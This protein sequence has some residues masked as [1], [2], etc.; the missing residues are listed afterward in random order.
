M[1]GR[2]KNINYAGSTWNKWDLHVHSNASDGKG[3]PQ[4]IID[5]ALEM[6]LSVIALTDHHTVKNI[7]E[8]KQLG[9][10]VGI[11]V[12][13]GIEF[14]TEYGAKSVHMIG[15]FPDKY[16][17]M[18]LDQKA[19]EQLILNKLNLSEV[20][21]KAK[22]KEKKP[23]A[24]DEEA[25]KIGMFKVQVDFKEASDL[26]H[27]YGGLVSVHAG[28]KANSIEEMK[29][30]GQAKKNVKDVVDSLGPLKEELLKEYI[31]ICE[32]GSLNDKNA[33]FYINNYNTP[34]IV[35]SDAHELSKIGSLYTWI[36]GDKDFEGLRQIVYE[37]EQRVKIQ[38]N[39]PEI[40]GDYQVIESLEVEHIDFGKQVIP[41]NPNLNSII[42]GRS[43]GKSILLGCIAKLAN[44]SGAIKQ[45]NE[46]YEKYVSDV[47]K[48]MKL[49][50]KD[51]NESV[52]RKVE[53]FPQSYINKLASDSKET[54]SLIESI[55]KGDEK[56]KNA[57]EAYD[58]STSKNLV[59]ISNEIENLFKLQYRED[60]LVKEIEKIGDFK[61]IKLEIDKL[62]KEL[63]IAKNASNTRISGDEEQQYEK[64]K[65]EREKLNSLILKNENIGRQLDSLTF[66]EVT[67]EIS[68]DLIGLPE[69]IKAQII[70]EYDLLK[71]DM[72]DKWLALVE[73]HKNFVYM[74]KS[75]AEARINEIKNCKEY[76]LGEAFYKE[77]A[78]IE[79]L[80]KRLVVE[81]LKAEKIGDLNNK[82]T[83]V[84]EEIKKSYCKI[85]LKQ[86]NYY[87]I[88]ERI[89]SS[90]SL[91]KDEVKI[92]PFQKF[93]TEKFIQFIDVNLNKRNSQIAGLMEY[94]YST[95]EDFFKLL[96]SLFSGIMEEKISLKGNREKKQI[97]LDL[98]TNN[99]FELHYEVIYQGD[100]LSSMSE[101]KKAF[102]I[103]R[104]LLDF[105]GNECPILIDQP[106]D[107]LDNRA[108]YNDLV[109]YIR[110]KKIERQIIV[111]TH[112]PN[113]V[114]AADSEEIIVANQHGSHNENQDNVKF[115]YRTG[116]IENS[117]KKQD[118]KTVL[119]SQGIREHICDILEGGDVAFKKREHKYGMMTSN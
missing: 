58:N 13:S 60:E 17:G 22:G 9:K 40:K 88:G 37:P 104:M 1:D 84:Q 70:E 43:S 109:T 105:N 110:N 79:E 68:S 72:R 92:T 66:I 107:D 108:I 19:L 57:F 56:R 50:W 115:E 8:I 12:I 80:S 87:D 34:A 73:K 3:T 74:Q 98:M 71:S 32:L 36:K 78:V 63:E 49:R 89:C 99:Y 25:F 82:I 64:L 90:V 52:S 53:Y 54:V 20:I 10:N 103:L 75:D 106:E 61:G 5:K 114:V 35:A 119:L 44:Y 14:R 7:D 83:E 26:I 23:T 51:G 97:V 117:C 11:T 2:V 62:T 21:L 39:R 4:E 118:G 16:N 6:E 42:G 86:E 38:T 116:A 93:N 24:S 85:I 77:N 27:Q 65:K 59:D 113:V 47:A 102:V 76:A 91:E 112:N 41:L 95:K 101:G 29:H 69:E 15:L 33:L 94:D 46:D 55:L 31:D 67:K 81:N 18:D 111:V 28:D 30:E 96:E 48:A 45:G 100:T